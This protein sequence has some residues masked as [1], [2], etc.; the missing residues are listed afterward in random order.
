MK[1]RAGTGFS[2]NQRHEGLAK[3]R[4]SEKFMDATGLTKTDQTR[5]GSGEGIRAWG[6]QS[7]TTVQAVFS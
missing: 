3:A 1:T 5:L 4:R 6:L 7:E 2:V